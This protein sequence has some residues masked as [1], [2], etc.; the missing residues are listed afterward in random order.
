MAERDE[1]RDSTASVAI[2]SNVG[3]EA[4]ECDGVNGRI[5]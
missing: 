1:E 5:L 3:G 4:S 2:L